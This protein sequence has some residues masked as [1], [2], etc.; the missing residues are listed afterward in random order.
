MNIRAD[1]YTLENSGKVFFAF[2][3]NSRESS[4]NFQ[5]NCSENLGKVIE[6]L[7]NL[8]IRLNIRKQG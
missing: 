8:K 7:K 3:E 1:E 5:E 6:F 4:Q 2:S